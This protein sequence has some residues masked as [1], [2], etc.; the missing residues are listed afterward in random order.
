ME[1]KSKAPPTLPPRISSI[2]RANTLA[3]P[4]ITQKPPVEQRASTFK[5]NAQESHN[6]ETHT[7][8][9][10]LP[11]ERKK[12]KSPPKL[13]PRL[14]PPITPRKK[15]SH[16][17]IVPPR[18]YDTDSTVS[19]DDETD[20]EIKPTGIQKETSPI[21]HNLSNAD[22]YFVMKKLNEL[23][24][25]MLQIMK[26]VEELQSHQSFLEAEIIALKTGHNFSSDQQEEYTISPDM[27]VTDVSK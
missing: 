2:K 18:N 15:A 27:R 22:T 1:Q 25:N 14:P 21:P 10:P 4:M 23:Q 26:Q 8:G 24:E 7:S 20:S 13:P 11:T 3:A 16:Y 19:A 17:D 6:S 12:L 5:R 9:A